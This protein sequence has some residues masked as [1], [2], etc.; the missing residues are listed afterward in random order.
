V[1]PI[2]GALEASGIAQGLRYSRWGY[3][4]VNTAH[5]F[6]IALLVG[7]VLPLDLR[8]LGVW[9]AVPRAGLVRVL[10]P[11]AAFG[12]A[13]AV[14]M[15]ALL[16]AT[17]APEYA[18]VGVFQVKLVLIATGTIA[19]LLLHTRFGFLLDGASDARLRAH[20][21]LSIFCW[22]GALVCGRLIA[23]VAG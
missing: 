21:V 10:V 3:A 16:F 12:L 8:F 22:I 20:A 18:D 9:K 11:V 5:V 17:R 7:A 6:G 2:L 4:A 15:G 23:F 1:E 13:L 14:A 19:A